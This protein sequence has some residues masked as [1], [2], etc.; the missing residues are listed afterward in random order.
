MSYSESDKLLR[1][2]YRA[3]V[4]EACKDPRVK[5]MAL[6]LISSSIFRGKRDLAGLLELSV[7]ALAGALESS[8]LQEAVLVA[9]TLAPA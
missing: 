3:S 6:P 2:A 1:D 8:P 4:R 9:H 5:T 7:K